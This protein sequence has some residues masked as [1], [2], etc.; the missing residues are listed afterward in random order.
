MRELR[1]ALIALCLIPLATASNA[2]A[3]ALAPHRAVYDLSL[4]KATDRSGIEGITGRMVY[5]FEGSACEGYTTT[6]RFVTRILAN[7]TTRVTDQQ[8]TTYESGD[9]KSFEF[10]TRS[11]VDRALDSEVR[12]SARIEGGKTLV[13]MDEPEEASLS[14]PASQFPTQHMLEL[15]GK[16]DSGENFYV[17]SIFDGSD[18]G[19]K[20]LTTSVVIGDEE[21]PV[22]S[23]SEAGALGSLADASYRPVDIAYFDG[24]DTGGEQLPTYRIAF[25]MH[26][27]G[28]TR[29]LTMDYGDFAI[30][31][32]LVDLEILERPG[33]SCD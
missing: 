5:Q 32:R 11:F 16:A 1:L 29:D 10:S 13:E 30:S 23:D 3:A 4:D 8:T 14:L 28:V 9:G 26:E 2:A 25:K 21:Q 24:A 33:Q 15:L 7:D 22:A 20:V 12:G 27:N 17:T 18:E 6:F 31:G 19:E